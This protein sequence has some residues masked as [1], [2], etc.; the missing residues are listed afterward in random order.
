MAVDPRGRVWAGTQHG[1]AVFA[2]GRFQPVHT[3]SIR[4][5][6]SVLNFVGDGEILAGGA[7]CLLRIRGGKT[8]EIPVHASLI[9]SILRT[10]QGDLLVSGEG[11]LDRV[12]A[13]RAIRQENWN[14]DDALTLLEDSRGLLWISNAGGGLA[15][16]GGTRPSNRPARFLPGSES[17][18]LA[19][20]ED[21]QG[22]VWAGTRSGELHRFRPH[23]F[24]GIGSK[25]GLAA[26]YVYSV[27]ADARGSIWIG[28][29]QGLNE[30]TPDGRLRLFT[31]QD[32]LPNLHVNAICGAAA[33]GLWIGTSAGIMRFE[34]GQFT[35]PPQPATLKPGVRGVLEDREGNLWV[36]TFRNGVEVLRGASWTHYGIE[37][38]LGSLAAR[39]LY[40]DS[41]GAV[42]V[43]TGGG[44]TRFENRRTTL[45]NARSGMPNDSATV[46][47]EDE[48][49]TL[50]AG[51]PAGLVRLRNGVITTF[52]VEAGISSAV[53]QITGDLKGN[54]WLGTESGILR[55]SRAELDAYKGPRGPA[56]RVVHYGLD[57]GLPSSSCSV[58]T[59]PL[60][61]RSGDGRLWF[62][63]TRGLAVL[64]PASW[65]P[66]PVP[67]TVLIDGFVADREA[68]VV[69]AIAVPGLAD[70]ARNGSFVL[71]PAKRTH[72]EFYYSA[73]NLLG[74]G[75]VR[76]RYKLEG[77]DTDWVEASGPQAASYNRM[78]PGEYRF[79]VTA[80][81]GDGVWTEQG[82]AI[83][84]RLA[85]YFYETWTFYVL[86][87]VALL[88]GLAAIYRLRVRSLHKTERQLGRLVQERTNE[89]Q[90]AEA[91]ARQAS[92]EAQA[93]NQVKS[94]FLANMS[95]EIRTP[96]NG[97]I[98]MT[99]LLLDTDLTPEQRDFAETVRVS[100]EALLIVINDILDFSKIE[101][102]MLAIESLVF[103]LRLVME[104]VG[105]ML[106]SK[107]EEKR[108]DLVLQYP[109]HLPR[110]FLGDAGRIRQ[111][112]TNL[113]GNA[114]KF[115]AQGFIL[116]DVECEIKDAQS[117]R[118]RVSVHDTGCGVPEEKI[119]AL[120][121]KFSQADSSTTRKYGG[122]GLGLAISKQLAE[123]MG[124]S[125]GAR[126]SPGEGS[127]FWFTLP[128][129]LDPHT[130]AAPAPV[131]GLRGLRV[132]IVDDNQ[133]NRRVLHE[134]I[135]SWGMRSESLSSGEQV[136]DA[137]RSAK[138][139]GDPYT[140]VLLDY[141]MQGMD[142]VEVAGAIKADPA[143]RDTVVVLLT[144]V[145][146][147][148]ELKRTEGARVDA[149]LVKPVRQSQLM[150]TL[151]AAW[152][153]KLEIAP[154]GRSPSARGAAR[155]AVQV[156]S[157]LAGEFAGLAVRVLV[158]EDNPVNRKVATLML[159]KLGIRPDLAA[160]GA[161]AV[162][163]FEVTPY[164]LI[165]MDCQM[166]ELDGYAASRKIRSREQPGHRVTIVAMTAE[167]MEGSREACLEAGM[168]DYI[169]K[170]V[171]RNEICE[172]LRK[173]LAP[174]G[175]EDES[176]GLPG[177]RSRSSSHG[178][179]T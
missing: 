82:A 178:M 112:L 26:D 113:V 147:W 133:V 19:L 129:E 157:K 87:A 141:Q 13:G 77:W 127:T 109:S 43:G 119:E 88:L 52:G 110:H 104:D 120:F 165:F 65:N 89:L 174:R 34:D 173:W 72:L 102:G 170:P 15:A 35:M 46:V 24:L 123:L 144:S 154:E 68:I 86:T 48:R 30:L 49:K 125:I 41:G 83:S 167:A 53:E 139:S 8:E 55:V 95:H 71:V 58:S 2:G 172:A 66:D 134:Q 45:Y 20:F 148:C 158:A 18:V 132:L 179:L 60:A 63:T 40:Q 3:D 131:A 153:K 4:G 69:D 51:S 166:P 57:D 105:E 136:L 81:N 32:G 161:E 9:T 117:A 92:L 56:V 70:R 114:V 7:G 47:Y 130:Q 156:D 16:I 121:Q 128:L 171:K 164:D 50:W 5:P 103:D 76:F 111:V 97:V 100:G 135:A 29:P 11:S 163:M 25:E 137:L 78:K 160:N 1:I 91:R 37:D 62:A 54:L 138:E 59:H 101:A 175:I 6:V 146:Q 177:V 44:L 124:G 106:A 107:A 10:R 99:G 31:K 61:T 98:G 155:G 122:T 90:M 94:E 27:F 33:G 75:K 64:D 80:S 152:S 140:F 150:K 159:G 39:E 126:S 21:R 151:A 176:S 108:L 23:V 74:G 143:I 42:W 17:E 12:V 142:G 85:S 118:M 162:Q 36:A 116:I 168:D 79:R 96:M 28:G 115:T 22:S 93:A 169:S 38:G 73:V 67:P 14:V 145:G 84:F 149:S